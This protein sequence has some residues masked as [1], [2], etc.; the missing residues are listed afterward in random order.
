MVFIGASDTPIPLTSLE[1]LRRNLTVAAIVNA[2]E[3]HFQSALD[4]LAR[5][6]Q[7]WLDGFV[8]RRPFSGWRESLTLTPAAPKV[9]H[10]MG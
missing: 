5:F 7:V 3:M 6:P 2:A 10:L 4:D 8:E 9:V 1:A